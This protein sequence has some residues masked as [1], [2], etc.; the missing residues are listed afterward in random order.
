VE[1]AILYESDGLRTR[2]ECQCCEEGL[3]P[4]ADA[5]GISSL[6]VRFSAMRNAQNEVPIFCASVYHSIIANLEFE[7]AGE[8]ATE[9]FSS[10][11]LDL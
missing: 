9:R 8:S 10:T 7:Q 4:P 5:A 1:A 3:T 2:R 6:S 11:R